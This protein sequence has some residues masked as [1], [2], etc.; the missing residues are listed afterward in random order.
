MLTQT[1]GDVISG[2]VTSGSEEPASRPRENELAPSNC[3]LFGAQ[4]EFYP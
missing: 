2:E 3:C 1:S 4:E